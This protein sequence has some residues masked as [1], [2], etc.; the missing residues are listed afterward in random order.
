MNGVQSIGSRLVTLRYHPPVQQI[1]TLSM[2]FNSTVDI[3]V[4]RTQAW[5]A[6]EDMALRPGWQPALQSV[7]RK[8]GVAGR[9]GA[10]TELTYGEGDRRIVMRETITER[11][12]PDFR[13]AI[14]E[15]EAARM[16][17]VDTFET[18]GDGKTRWT[19]W[20]NVTYRGVARILS[21]FTAASMRKRI[22]ADMQ[23][24]KLLVETRAAG[25][26]T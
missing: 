23:R 25:A 12:Q 26:A 7:E 18:L 24:F 14:F 22:E 11:R 13:A 2:K 19:S 17:V 4:A 16:L 5:S 20:V 15:T 10:V 3:S 21:L 6:Y 8:S 1:P 9:P